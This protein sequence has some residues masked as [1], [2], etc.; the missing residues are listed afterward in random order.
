MRRINPDSRRSGIG[1]RRGALK[2]LAAG[3]Q[4]RAA[5]PLVDYRDANGT[6][7]VVLAGSPAGID[8]RTHRCG[9]QRISL[10]NTAEKSLLVLIWV[11]EK[12]V[13]VDLYDERDLRGPPAGDDPR[14]PQC[15]SHRIAVALD[16]QVDD[17]LRVKVIGIRRERGLARV[18]HALVER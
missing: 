10:V 9:P 15:G 6:A 16:G 18:F 8:R 13:M 4:P 12:F 11:S 7:K 14:H 1:T 17:V 2:H 3:N 5:G